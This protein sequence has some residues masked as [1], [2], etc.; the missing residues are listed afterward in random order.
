MEPDFWHLRWRENRIG[1]HQPAV[2]PHLEQYWSRLETGPGGAVFVPLCGKSL[3]MCWLAERHERVIGVELSPIAV[4]A[5]FTENGLIPERSVAGAL[6]IFDTG[7][8]RI[9]C[10]DFFDLE[11][12]LLGDVAAAYDR[13]ALT[14]LP[15]VMR[16]AYVARLGAL[17]PAA[18]PVLLVTME[19]PVAQMEGPP[20]AVSE[21]EIG[22]LFAGDWS[23]EL[24]GEVDILEREPRFRER[25]LS[26]LSEKVYLLR[27][28]PA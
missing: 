7:A 4:E 21:A 15:P 12:A 22:R 1:F 28:P 27:T 20:F 19:Y 2:S 23:I 18:T 3:D 5:F 25:G 24:L 8:I 14:A 16:P 17:L 11:P 9:C 13:A 10:G 6:E 26:R